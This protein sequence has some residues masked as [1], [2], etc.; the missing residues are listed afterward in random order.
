MSFMCEKYFRQ[1][2]IALILDGVLIKTFGKSYNS[3]L[4]IF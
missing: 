4:G 2:L 3:K 1:C